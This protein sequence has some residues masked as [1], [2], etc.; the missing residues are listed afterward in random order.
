MS[1][2]LRYVHHTRG[3][4]SSTH[5]PLH[6][7]QIYKEI[8]KGHVHCEVRPGTSYRLDS[9]PRKIPSPVVILSESPMGYSII[10][11]KKSLPDLCPDGYGGDLR[12]TVFTLLK[13][14]P[15]WKFYWITLKTKCYGLRLEAWVRSRRMVPDLWFPV[16]FRFL[17]LEHR[18]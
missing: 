18:Q 7:K 17:S 6:I 1:R 16:L 3:V 8:L 15:R 2:H 9:S 14:Y 11:S 12:S 5:F 4:I 13:I 10:S